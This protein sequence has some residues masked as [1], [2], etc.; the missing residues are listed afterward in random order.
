MAAKKDNFWIAVIILGVFVFFG[1]FA[2]NLGLASLNLHIK[3]DLTATYLS[4]VRTQ[5][6]DSYTD[7]IVVT[8]KSWYA[9]SGA[10]VIEIKDDSTPRVIAIANV[11]GMTADQTRTFEAHYIGAPGRYTLQVTV[12]KGNQ[13]AEVDDEHNNVVTRVVT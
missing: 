1:V 3:P 10:F 13:V 9:N 4:V 5:V 6:G 8:V 12:D 2:P 7:T 11:E